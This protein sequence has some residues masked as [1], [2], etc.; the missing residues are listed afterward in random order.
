MK[1]AR[2]LI[3]AGLL[4]MVL[5]IC[6]ACASKEEK[7]DDMISEGKSLL[8]KEDYDKAEKK[9]DEAI[10]L[11]PGEPNAYLELYKLY[12]ELED[13]DLAEDVLNE[14]LDAVEDRSGKK[15]LEKKQDEL[16]TLV[17]SGKGQDVITGTPTPTPD[18]YGIDYL[19][20][21]DASRKSTDMENYSSIIMCLQVALADYDVYSHI[22]NAPDS[23]YISVVINSEGT[24]IDGVSETMDT[25][26]LSDSDYGAWLRWGIRNTLPEWNKIQK[27]SKYSVTGYNAAGVI[28]TEDYYEIRV[29]LGKNCTVYKTGLNPGRIDN[30]EEDNPGLYGYIG[31]DYATPIPTEPVTPTPDPNAEMTLVLWDN[32]TEISSNRFAYNKAL[33]ELKRQYPKVTIV[34][35]SYE[36]DYYKMKIKAA[37][38]ANEMPDIFMAYSGCFLKDFVEAGKVYSLDDTLKQYIDSG[39]ISEVM[40]GNSTYSGKCYGAPLAYNFVGFYANMD[41]LE[42]A[43]WYEI[44]KTIDEL[45]ECCEALLAN[46]ITPFDIGGSEY[47]C[48]SEWIEPIIEKSIGQYTMRN[49]MYQYDTWNNKIIADAI[50]LFQSMIEKGYFGTDAEKRNND[51]AKNNF[52]NGRCAF[53]QN[54]TWNNADI[55]YSGINVKIGEFPV[56]NSEYSQLGELIGGSSEVLAVANTS[57]NVEKAAEIAVELSRMISNYQYLDSAG[58]SPWRV[59]KDDS[60]VI[61]LTREAQNLGFNATSFMLFGDSAMYMDDIGYYIEYVSKIFDGSINGE[62]FIAELSEYLR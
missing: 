59:Y 22:S 49:I 37:L 61:E 43:G 54:G 1:A 36:Y 40:L 25:K 30:N 45:T 13:Y 47:W 10:K 44:P 14:G 24:G 39:E 3:L 31:Y 2:K 38:A 50:D 53:Y 5:V 48:V 12:V 52:M 19:D 17:L 62:S 33:E 42:K 4:V 56:I 8:R 11:L 6:A 29:S 7:Y 55:A 20:Y 21:L 46:G 23:A 16:K 28:E 58:L 9:F 15:K 51:E 60:Y 27:K 32:A 18:T 26:P 34:E 35:E 41:L 57:K